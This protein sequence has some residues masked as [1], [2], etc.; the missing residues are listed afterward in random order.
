M[1]KEASVGKLLTEF[2]RKRADRVPKAALPTAKTDL[3]GLPDTTTSIVWLGHSSYFIQA[4]N[5]RILVDPV[6]S[7]H[8]S[9]IKIFGKAFPGT[10]IY[11]A[12]EMPPV[13]LLIIT[14]DHYDHLDYETIRLFHPRASHIVTAQG[15][16]THLRYWK[17]PAEKITELNWW[18]HTA[19]NP[20]VNITA[21]PARH[22]S[23]RKFTRATTLWASFV[24]QV[25]ATRFFIGGDS[26]YDQQFKEIGDR[27]G[28]FDIAFLESGQYG[29]YW[30]LIH[31]TPEETVQAAIDLRTRVLMPV[32]WGKFALANHAWYDPINRVTNAAQ[33]A[34]IACATPRI[35]QAFSLEASLPRDAWWRSYEKPNS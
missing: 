5:F 35:G 31:M 8:A 33:V 4:R 23:G 10:D 1:V 26:G 14:H 18:Q 29:R 25:G 6:L 20:D 32:H 2:I 17:I 22:F 16:G 27:L 21:T 15:V 19:I 3:Y 7:G 30:P 12:N 34:G 24:L 28:P 9:P 13:D 11:T